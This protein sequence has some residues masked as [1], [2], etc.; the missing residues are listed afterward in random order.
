MEWGRWMNRRNT[1][2]GALAL[3][4]ISVAI[5]GVYS[6]GEWLDRVDFLR[7]QSFRVQQLENIGSRLHTYMELHREF[8]PRHI[9]DL[10]HGGFLASTEV[11]FEDRWRSVRI[12]RTFASPGVVLGNGKT[13][14]MVESYSPDVLG[15]VFMYKEGGADLNKKELCDPIVVRL[16]D[17]LSDP[18]PSN[19]L[20]E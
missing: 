18:A 15:C 11:D 2:T 6:Y 3:A 4:L 20:G 5:Y 10:I 13:V 12:R 9:E 19:E 14:L 8:N 1:K 17:R 16:S 7:W